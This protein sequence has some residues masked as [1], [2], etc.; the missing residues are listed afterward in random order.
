[1]HEMS[2]QCRDELVIIPVQVKVIK[3]VRYVY[4]CRHCDRN[5]ISVPIVTAAGPAPLIPKSLAS[6]SAVAYIMSQKFVESMPLYRIEK[7]FERLGIKL[8]RQVL[9]NWMIKGGEKLEVIY[10]RMRERLLELDILHADES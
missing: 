10:D 5:E 1:M 6:A 2:S 8:P 4:G 7:H 3:H 9:S